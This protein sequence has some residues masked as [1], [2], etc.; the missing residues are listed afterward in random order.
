MQA[1]ILG[2]LSDRHPCLASTH[3]ALF[4][5]FYLVMVLAALI[6]EGLFALFGWMPLQRGLAIAMTRSRTTTPQY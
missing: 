5:S 4:V 2:A 1:A 3:S 6:V